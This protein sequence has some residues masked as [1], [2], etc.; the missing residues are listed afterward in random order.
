MA[1]AKTGED[2]RQERLRERVSRERLRERVSARLPDRPLPARAEIMEQAA[3]RSRAG[4]RSRRERLVETA[5][6]ILH[7]SVAA[8]AAWYVAHDLVG[9]TAPFFAPT[10]AVVTLGLT[11]GQRRRRA[12]EIGL[13]VAV[14]ILVADLLVSVIGTG[15]W[16]IALL[17]GLA[18]LVATALGGG[19]LVASQAGISAVLVGTIQTPVDGFSFV[20]FEDA[21]IGSAVALLVGSLV[22]PVDPIALARASA[23]PLLERLAR[24]LDQIAASLE[25]RHLETAERALV[26]TSELES[27][28]TRLETSLEAAHDAARLAP[29]QRK[30]R[31]KL[32]RYTTVAH[33]IGL[34]PANVR[35]LAR[36]ATRAITLEDATPEELTES[37]HE[38]AATFRELIPYLEGEG[39]EGVRHHALRAAKLAN[40]VLGETANL[41][42]LHLVG[43]VRLIAVDLLRAVGD[44]R[45]EALATVREA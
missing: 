32:S 43:Q 45:K 10:S 23:E 40:A 7:T 2:T 14:G 26:T 24:V 1:D 4:L 29:G 12:V 35:V 41:S 20:R 44:S 31:D 42:A 34:A 30:A 13:G 19:P 3:E 16:Q 33:E 28:Y 11:V 27:E 15:T 6:P 38:L 9:H 21:A 22:F 17:T 5:R 25:E 39:D 8:A 36:G 37:L 18:M